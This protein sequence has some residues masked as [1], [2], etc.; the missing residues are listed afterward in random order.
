M[1][2]GWRTGTGGGTPRKLRRKKSEGSSAFYFLT[3]ERD[4]VLSERFGGFRRRSVWHRGV[5]TSIHRL[6]TAATAPSEEHDAIAANLRGVALVAVF[7]VPLACL[8]T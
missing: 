1:S 2:S 7:V 6:T 8:K 3:S 4:V 5:T